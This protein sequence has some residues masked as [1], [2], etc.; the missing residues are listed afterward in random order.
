MPIRYSNVTTSITHMGSWGSEVWKLTAS[1]NL[2]HRPLR[3]NEV[4]GARPR[5]IL[6]VP[7]KIQRKINKEVTWGFSAP[8]FGKGKTHI[9]F[10]FLIQ[11]LSMSRCQGSWGWRT[12]LFL[13]ISVL[14]QDNCLAVCL[15]SVLFWNF[16]VLSEIG[17]ALIQIRVNKSF[18]LPLPQFLFLYR[19][20][21]E[22][23]INVLGAYRQKRAFQSSFTWHAMVVWI[24]WFFFNLCLCSCQM[25]KDNQRS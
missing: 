21:D 14:L 15:D 18:Q 1:H 11:V 6:K 24:A 13:Q 19:G 23:Y 2:V 10:V 25:I 20:N 4:W 7:Q 5:V 8:I 22:T 17:T 9:R 3:S 16:F 12:T